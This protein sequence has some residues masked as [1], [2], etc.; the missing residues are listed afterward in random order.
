[1]EVMEG[2]PEALV[3]CPSEQQLLDVGKG[4]QFTFV[5]SIGGDPSSE[6]PQKG[7]SARTKGLNGHWD[8]TDKW[9]TI[10]LTKTTRIIKTYTLWA[11]KKTYR[12][13]DEVGMV[14]TGI[15]CC[16]K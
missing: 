8:K 2:K 7:T 1:M 5:T 13:L 11:T 16:C 9:R 12:M 10:T 3:N 6:V 15:V 14:F 4:T